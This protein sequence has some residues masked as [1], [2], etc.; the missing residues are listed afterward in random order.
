MQWRFLVGLMLF[1]WVLGNAAWAAD[2]NRDGR[3]D[4]ADL[5]L[6]EAYLKGEELFTEAQ[7]QAADLNQDGAVTQADMKLLRQSLEGKVAAPV[8]IRDQPGSASGRVIDQKTGKPLGGADIEVP[9]EGIRVTA[10]SEGRFTLPPNLP[11]NRILTVRAPN[12]TPFSLTTRK[13]QRTPFDLRLE[14]KNARSIVLDDQVHHLGDDQFGS[15]SA[16]A[17]QLRRSSEGSQF[18]RTFELAQLPDQDP[19]LRIGSLV[20]I[21]TPDSVAAGQSQLPVENTFRIGPNAAFR[22]YL[23]GTLVQRI[24]VNGDNI[25]IPLTRKLLKIGSNELVLVTAS[26]AGQT[27]DA[28]VIAALYGEGRYNGTD[29]DDIEFAHLVLLLPDREEVG[30]F[31]SS[32]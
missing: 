27:A 12:Y 18:K 5:Q 24:T 11:P 13:D 6:L 22:V 15:T 1:G 20:G 8:A 31:H 21:D 25:V 23:N 9:Q 32:P 17:G 30:S 19:Y 26:A 14:Q 7:Q 2:L 3:M 29:Y 16:N 4:Q 10:D 28:S